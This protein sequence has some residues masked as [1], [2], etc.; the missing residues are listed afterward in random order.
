M[1][2]VY[3][4]PDTDQ[5]PVV[6]GLKD[7]NLKPL[8]TPE[9]AERIKVV[10]CRPDGS[11]NVG[12]VCRA[13]GS[14]GYSRLY[15]VGR[16]KKF[17]NRG[18]VGSM[19]VNSAQ[20]FDNAEFLPGLDR[21]TAD[22]SLVIGLTRRRGSRRKYF[23]IVPYQL[24]ERVTQTRGRIALLFGNERIGLDDEELRYCNLACHIPTHP[25]QPSLN[26]SHAVQI[27]LY[28]LS[29]LQGHNSGLTPLTQ[30]EVGRLSMELTGDMQ[31]MG[32]EDRLGNQRTEVFLRDI[33]SRA[34]LSDREG[35]RLQRMFHTLRY[36]QNPE[37][38][39]DQ[40]L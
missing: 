9:E 4:V 5:S 37:V 13:M 38:T 19:G 18:E 25:Q 29:K 21:I 34:G 12:S 27:I 16:D 33:L 2:D 35:Q 24:C 8:C 3:R 22:C 28:E 39:E 30:E 1:T 26:L 11:R 31:A 23:S 20:L 14:M 40:G 6:R 15:I 10:L 36:K 17:F 7:S 32:L